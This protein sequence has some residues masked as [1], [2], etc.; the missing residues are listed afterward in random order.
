MEDWAGKGSWADCWAMR[1]EKR[2]KVRK[3]EGLG[4]AKRK[5]GERGKRNMFCNKEDQAHSFEF[6]FEEFKFN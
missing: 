2:G 4:R 1:E 6:K 3:R 5:K